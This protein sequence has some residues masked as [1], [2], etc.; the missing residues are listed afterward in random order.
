MFG[1][2][3]KFSTEFWDWSQCD[4]V[5][6][7]G[8]PALS[9]F[10]TSTVFQNMIHQHVLSQPIFSFY[11][12][13]KYSHPDGE[14]LLGETNPSHYVGEFT[15]VNVTRK[16]YWQFK[17][18]RIQ[19]ERNTFCSEGCQAIVDTGFS[20]I[21]GPP[22]AITAL[23]R[24][25]GFNDRVEC[26]E[27]PDLPH[28][29]FVIGGTTFRL[30]GQDYVRKVTGDLCIL[31]LQNIDPFNDNGIEWILGN[32]FIRRYYTVFDMGKDRVGFAMADN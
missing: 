9:H 18:D 1:E 29:I 16:K 15:Y 26:R 23:K 21:A 17:M 31:T 30:T 5:L 6:G 27:I 7:M 22:Q 11:L 25:I 32:V 10:N 8:Y 3:L 28:I 2:V 24:E 20:T 13:R 14:L 4:G 19:T 12:N